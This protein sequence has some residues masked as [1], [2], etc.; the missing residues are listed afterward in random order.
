M[1]LVKTVMACSDRSMATQTVVAGTVD[2]DDDGGYID[3]CQVA[4]KAVG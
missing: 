2:G 4:R 1:K 3:R